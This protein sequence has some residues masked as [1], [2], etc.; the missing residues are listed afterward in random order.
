MTYK[1]LIII[2]IAINYLNAIIN[3]VKIINCYILNNKDNN[4]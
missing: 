2:I 3:Q 4:K 1:I